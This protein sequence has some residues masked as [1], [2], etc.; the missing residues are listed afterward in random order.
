MNSTHTHRQHLI[1]SSWFAVLET[2]ILLAAFHQELNI[3]FVSMVSVLFVLK[4]FHWLAGDRVDYV[5]DYRMSV[6][7]CWDDKV[8]EPR[9]HTHYVNLDY[10]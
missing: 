10:V 8:A 2:F 5:R 6:C 3:S 9:A 1:E 7:L 4:S